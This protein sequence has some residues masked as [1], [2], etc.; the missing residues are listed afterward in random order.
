MDA[1]DRLLCARVDAENLIHHSDHDMKYLLIRCTERWIEIGIE[2]SAGSIGHSY[3]N[4]LAGAIIQAL[5]KEV[6]DQVG[7]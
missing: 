3:D 5:K 6:V 7:P 2:A 1:L 4:S